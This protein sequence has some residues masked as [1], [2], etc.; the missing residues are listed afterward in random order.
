MYILLIQLQKEASEG[1]KK[2][3]EDEKSILEIADL[4]SLTESAIT[5]LLNPVN[6]DTPLNFTLNYTNGGEGYEYEASVDIGKEFLAGSFSKITLRLVD[7]K[8]TMTGNKVEDWN[9]ITLDEIVI[10]GTPK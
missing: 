4:S 8:L 9:V 7:G 1:M 10:T 5:V 3:G 6:L 2:S